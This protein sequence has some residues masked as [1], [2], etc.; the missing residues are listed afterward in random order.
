MIQFLAV[1]V[2][3]KFTSVLERQ[4]KKVRDIFFLFFCFC[5]V[6]LNANIIIP[7]NKGGECKGKKNVMEVIWVSLLFSRE[8]I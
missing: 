1:Y 4:N 5:F 3:S 8:E 7:E 2:R 6:I